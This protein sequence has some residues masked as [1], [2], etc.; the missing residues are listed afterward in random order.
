MLTRHAEHY[1]L[2]YRFAVQSDEQL[3]DKFGPHAIPHTVLIDRLGI[4]RMVRIGDD[5]KAV[6][7]LEDVL[8]K[9]IAEKT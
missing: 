2:A 5:S 6:R 7:D 4:F 3:Y 9:L 8:K 1:E